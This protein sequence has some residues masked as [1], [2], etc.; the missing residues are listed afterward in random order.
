MRNQMHSDVKVTIITVVWNDAEGFLV[1]ARSVLAQSYDNIEWIVID[2]ASTDGTSQY[3]RNLSPAISSYVIEKD[4]GI[5]NAMNKGI[6][7][8]TGDWIM[9]MN[10]DDAFYDERIV[11]YYVNNIQDDDSVLYSDVIRRE[12][13]QIH[14]YLSADRYW[15]GMTLD[16]QSAFVRSDLYKQYK[17]DE[18]YRVAGDLNF[19]S[20]L[21]AKSYKFRKLNGLICCI[22]P[23]G[24]GASSSYF[25]RQH[26]R[27]NVLRTYFDGP[28]LITTLHAEFKKAY[29]SKVVTANEFNKLLTLIGIN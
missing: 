29:D 18:R 14:P 23:F 5:Y 19:I 10:A 13:G 22:K 27:V 21:K 20:N 11:A 7:R 28:Q 2:G 8:A 1:T 16:H 12:D 15:L 17:F 3:V 24:V 6:D 9:F 26:E 4:T 25:D